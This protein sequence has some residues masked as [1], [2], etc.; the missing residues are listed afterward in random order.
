VAIAV[1]PVVRRGLAAAIARVREKVPRKSVRWVDADNVH[2][3]LRFIGDIPASDLDPMRRAL[4]SGIRGA[5]PFMLRLAQAGCFPEGGSPRV[6]WVGLGGDL[7][8]LARLQAQ[9]LEATRVWGQ[10]EARAFHPHLT[11]GR[12]VA[13]RAGEMR[14]IAEA[15][16]VFPVP[17][18]SP[19]RVEEVCLMQSVL[20]AGGAEYSVLARF[21]LTAGGASSA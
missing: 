4:A 20:A 8:R 3:T 15:M 9:V 1:P 7:E 12:V 17:A 2:L 6:L 10:V 14:P 19:W 5:E 18:C 11:L 16:G 21:N 13:R